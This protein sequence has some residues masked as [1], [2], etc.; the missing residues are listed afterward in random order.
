[1]WIARRANL[2]APWQAPANLGPKI[3]SPSGDFLP[4]ISPDGRTLYF[5]SDRTGWDCWQTAIDPNLDF[6][7]DGNVDEKDLLV[8][9]QHW[10]ENYP[11]CDIG[12]FPW[13][14]GVV[15]E[16]DLKAFT[17]AVMTPGPKASDVPCDVVLSWISPAFA[18]SCDVYLG[19]SF[20]AV[21]SADRVNP[22]GVLVSQ[23]QTTTAYDPAGLLELSRT[24]YWRTDFVV[25]GPTP[26]I[27]KGPVLEFT[28]AALTY[29]IKNI[30]ATASSAQVG[31]GP[32]R[33]LDGSG[34]DKN[35]GHSTELMDMWWSMAEPSHWIQY[36]FDR[37][38][39]LH[40]MWVWNM[41][42]IIEPFI[43]FGAK[44]V[45]IE[46]STDGSAWTSLA[47]VPEFAQ[48]PGQSG[49]LHDT[50]ITFG[51]APAKFVKLTIEKNWGVA[52]QTGLSEV[53]FFCIQTAGASKP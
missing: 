34:L 49:Y 47:N 46:Y 25:A 33:T 19:T 41:N 11:R 6:D 51:G 14:D 26:T 3:N 40:E 8:M 24:Y 20:E 12:P 45:K 43:G 1:M 27:Y 42:Q 5:L 30:T 7:T 38:Y 29:R 21:N 35:D 10:G 18:N 28:T 23:A 22:Q 44:T 4:R 16:D 37:V 15:D 9:T 52:P 2:S 31:S 50:T 53:R 39:T 32:E 13:G 17:E 48:A 36:E